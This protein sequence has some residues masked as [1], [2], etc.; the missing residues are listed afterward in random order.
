MEQ[1]D[2]TK[3]GIVKDT[4]LTAVDMMGAYQLYT[5]KAF[6]QGGS[7]RKALEHSMS[8]KAQQDRETVM[9]RILKG[10][11]DEEA[12]KEFLTDAYFEAWYLELYSQLE[13]LLGKE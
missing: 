13:A 5:T 10:K 8:A 12:Q 4:L 11:T 7:V 9:S 2:N 3:D 1:S 6:D